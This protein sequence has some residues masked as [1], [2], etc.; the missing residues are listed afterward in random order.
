MKEKCSDMPPACIFLSEKS[1][2]CENLETSNLSI[3]GKT[4]GGFSINRM[5][6]GVHQVIPCLRLFVSINSHLCNKA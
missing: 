3:S 4:V 5:G 2:T 6:P 1:R